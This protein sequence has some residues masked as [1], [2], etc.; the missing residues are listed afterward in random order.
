MEL[1]TSEK[2]H[3]CGSIVPYAGPLLGNLKPK[4]KLAGSFGIFDHT[5]VLAW[6]LAAASDYDT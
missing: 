4:F 6:R 3:F 1:S 2:A 5:F